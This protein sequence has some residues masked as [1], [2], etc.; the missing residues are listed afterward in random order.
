MKVEQEISP[1][2][3]GKMKVKQDISPPE[4]GKNKEEEKQEISPLKEVR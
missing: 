3:G 4:G 2:E 1:P